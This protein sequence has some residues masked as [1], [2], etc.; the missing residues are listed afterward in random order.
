MLQRQVAQTRHHQD[1]EEAEDTVEADEAAEAADTALEAV[2][3]TALPPEARHQ[4]SK[5]TQT[6]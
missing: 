6:A 2:E 5:V 3:E 4:C 1:G